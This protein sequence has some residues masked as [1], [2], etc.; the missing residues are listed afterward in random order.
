VEN[1]HERRRTLAATIAR[2]DRD[3]D[4]VVADDDVGVTVPDAG[5]TMPAG[6]V[7]LYGQA[8]VATVL[9]FAGLV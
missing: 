2:K 8:T 6:S 3:A 1:Y 5:R 7:A 9:P 4:A